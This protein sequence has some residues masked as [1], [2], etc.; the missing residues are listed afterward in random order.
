MPDFIPHKPFDDPQKHVE[1]FHE[2]SRASDRDAPLKF[3]GR[4][5]LF[6]DVQTCLN[7][8]AKAGKTL[9]NGLFIDGAPG[10]G[11][12]GFIREVEKRH[13]EK[14]TQVVIVDGGTLSRPVQFAEA[15]YESAVKRE[16]N[17]LS[18]FNFSIGT[19][20]LNFGANW[21]DIQSYVSGKLAQGG[22]VWS[23]IRELCGKHIESET[24]IVCVDEAQRTSGDE[25][26]RLNQIATQIHDGKTGK[27]QLLPI[28]AGLNDMRAR[29]KRAGVS[30]EAKGYETLSALSL[31]ESV[32]CSRALFEAP[33]LNLRGKFD[34]KDVERVSTTIAIASEGWPRHLHC[35]QTT[36]ALAMEKSLSA[37]QN[38]VNLDDVI[39]HGN[40]MR[41]QYAESRVLSAEIAKFE[42][43]IIEVARGANNG[44]LSEKALETVGREFGCS[45]S[46]VADHLSEA[47][48][49]GVL[50]R[51][52]GNASERGYVFPV[53]SFLRFMQN[54]M[55]VERTLK[56]MR[57]MLAAEIMQHA[58]RKPPGDESSSEGMGGFGG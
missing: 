10:V 37:D 12:S 20:G 56:D 2:L 11:K 25:G 19:S 31:E 38:Y 30:R 32:E 44:V 22:S 14:G 47:E 27:I 16:K 51:H 50:Q 15:F 42:N 26:K 45:E 48:H 39:E 23:A 35:Y 58:S 6:A 8:T 46:Q 28:F 34:E 36:F 4:D 7:I 57:E 17:A 52:R 40:R 24:I 53:P 54:D 49:C 29:L 3:V 21:E 18:S 5:N 55:N 41:I 13:G 9:S 43:V 1:I 33:A